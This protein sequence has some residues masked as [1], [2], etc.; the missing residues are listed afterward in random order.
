MRLNLIIGG[1]IMSIVIFI[2][3][4]V[5]VSFAPDALGE[6]LKPLLCPTG[7]YV[8]YE[9]SEWRNGQTHRL[10]NTDCELPSG[11]RVNVD[12]QQ[13]GMIML[14]SVT[15]IVV[16]ALLAWGMGFFRPRKALPLDVALEESKLQ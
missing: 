6:L 16:T 5:L 2:V 7:A 4:M 15:P 10:R 3:S 14:A 9:S 13:F 11:E 1:I 12:A 8:S